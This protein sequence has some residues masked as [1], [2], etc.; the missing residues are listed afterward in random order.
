LEK[1]LLFSDLED[2]EPEQAISNSGD[3]ASELI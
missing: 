2:N 3:I 1:D